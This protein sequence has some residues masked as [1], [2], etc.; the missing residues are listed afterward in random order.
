LLEVRIK[1][2]EKHDALPEHVAALTDVMREM[3]AAFTHYAPQLDYPPLTAAERCLSPS[4]FGF[5]N[6]LHDG[7]GR[8]S[9]I[10]FEYAGWDDPAKLLCDFLLHPGIPVD[11]ELLSY[12]LTPLDKAG[13]LPPPVRRRS[14]DLYPLLVLR[15]CCIILNVFV[16]E[17]AARRQF[18]D[19]AWNKQAAQATQLAK[20]RYML[21]K[22]P[23]NPF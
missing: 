16:P 8:F 10:D 23:T 11:V 4:D 18:S 22:I 9:F 5:H 6:S 2:L 15:W 17:H 21:Q 1:R 19:K 13:L 20:A 14:R 3:Q 12:L 7:Q